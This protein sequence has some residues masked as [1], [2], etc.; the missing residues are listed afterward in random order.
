MGKKD[1]I[2]SEKEK[3]KTYKDYLEFLL[4]LEKTAITKYS[5]HDISVLPVRK[6]IDVF[7][8]DLDYYL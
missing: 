5:H 7:Y 1:S 4:K 2:E 6:L 8:D 3:L